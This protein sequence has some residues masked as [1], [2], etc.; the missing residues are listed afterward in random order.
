M[1]ASGEK[2]MQS[3]RSPLPLLCALAGVVFLSSTI[4]HAESKRQLKNKVTPSYPELARRV[5]IKGAVRLELVVA[6]DGHVKQVTVLGGNPVLVQSAESAVRRW[7]YSAAN[8]ESTV[9]VQLDFDPD[10]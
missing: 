5:N 6:P 10:K 4:A 7:R 1:I 8:E 2:D 9:V 3:L